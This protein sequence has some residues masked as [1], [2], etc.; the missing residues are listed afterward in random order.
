[1]Y[2]IGTSEWSF[3]QVKMQSMY[4]NDG[5]YIDVDKV[6]YNI[7]DSKCTIFHSYDEANQT[8]ERIKLKQNEIKFVNNL[9]IETLLD[10]S[11]FD[12]D[13]LKVY[14]LVPA[15]VIDNYKK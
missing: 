14:E 7:N 2:V 1:M 11:M 6:I 12:V 5:V 10:N 13:A 3:I 15:E 4:S 9:I 8:L